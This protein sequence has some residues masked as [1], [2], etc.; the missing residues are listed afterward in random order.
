MAA[1]LR[2]QFGPEWVSKFWLENL[3]E[4]GRYQCQKG[5]DEEEK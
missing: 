4:P 3:G 5:R 1:A 2:L